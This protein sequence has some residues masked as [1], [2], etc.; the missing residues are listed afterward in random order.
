MIFFDLI[1]IYTVYWSDVVRKK[2]YRHRASKLWQILVFKGHNS[3]EI[4]FSI[5]GWQKNPNIIG[6]TNYDD[7]IIT[8]MTI[9]SGEWNEPRPS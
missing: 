8:L 6:C 2:K 3:D 7:K 4:K 5:G 1:S 9:I